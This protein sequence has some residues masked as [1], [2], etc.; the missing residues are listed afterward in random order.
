[1]RQAQVL[2]KLTAVQETAND[3][4]QLIRT[5]GAKLAGHWPT[6]LALV[7]AGLIGK[8]V[9]QQVALFAG[10][11]GWALGVFIFA[12][13][14]AGL[15]AAI[16][17]MFRS[18]L[19]TRQWP[20]FTAVLAPFLVIFVATNHF[21]GYQINPALERPITMD[22]A[23][24]SVLIVTIA[25]RWLMP[26]WPA[27]NNQRWAAWVRLGLDICWMSLVAF[28]IATHPLSVWLADLAD[29]V[30]WLLSTAFTVLVV[31]LA[32]LA[33]GGL[34]VGL[35][36]ADAPQLVRRAGLPV[37]LATC[38][39]IMVVQAIPLLLWEIE[40]LIIGAREPESWWQPV[41]GL[42]GAFNS[43]VGLLLVVCVV[44][45]LLARSGSDEAG[46]AGQ[47]RPADDTYGDRLG[48]GRRDEE[49]E[50]LVAV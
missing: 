46:I 36:P 33:V 6:L 48:G 13:T 23:A 26:L 28:T 1:M 39:I 2:S 27:V 30:S 40:R 50:D 35:R 18:M 37:V 19:P 25:L 7:F 31:P 44:A 21:D 34:A 8:L 49:D 45:A 12:F 9:T 22:V 29:P 14:A 38:L 15:L 43:A 11:L 32:W 3:V 41:S 17:L 42:L 4:Y 10:E 16:M 24:A 47:R 20:P 5:A